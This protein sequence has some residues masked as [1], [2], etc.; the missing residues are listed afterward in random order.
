MIGDELLVQMLD[1]PEP[2]WELR[3]AMR[4]LL[5]QGHDRS[6]LVARLA[7]FKETLRRAGR[8]DQEFDAVDDTIA[9]PI[10]YRSPH[11]RL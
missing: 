1:A 10:G 8:S 4:L 7:E 3:G 11:P 9:H 2:P 5:A 6:A